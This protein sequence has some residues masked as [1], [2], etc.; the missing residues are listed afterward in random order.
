MSEDIEIKEE[1][2]CSRALKIWF[3]ILMSAWVSEENETERINFELTKDWEL[4]KFLKDSLEWFFEKLNDNSTI[5]SKL[6]IVFL[7]FSRSI[8][9]TWD[10][11]VLFE[12]FDDRVF[13]VDFD[14]I[15]E[16][17]FLITSETKLLMSTNIRSSN[18]WFVR[19]KSRIWKLIFSIWL[20]IFSFINSWSIIQQAKQR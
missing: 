19:R 1:L 5:F 3:A 17:L 14:V 12:D 20:M 16:F 2:D 13:R 18:L 4:M 8:A 6:V 10:H 11:V 9:Q 7:N 15:D